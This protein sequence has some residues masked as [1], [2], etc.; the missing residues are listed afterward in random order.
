MVFFSSC[1][2][3]GLIIKSKSYIRRL[4]NKGKTVIDIVP[5][6]LTKF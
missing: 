4:S 3:L 5:L 6:S 1:G 2:L